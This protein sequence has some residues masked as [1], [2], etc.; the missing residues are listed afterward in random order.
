METTSRNGVRVRVLAT[1][2]GV[3]YPLLGAW[4]SGTNFRWYPIAWTKEGY[5]I[6]RENPSTLDINVTQEIKDA[7]QV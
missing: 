6:N 1:D 2:G 7:L 4:Y 5:I 3:D